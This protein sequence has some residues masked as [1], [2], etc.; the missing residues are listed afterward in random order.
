[1]RTIF[2]VGSRACLAC[3]C[4]LVAAGLASASTPFVIADFDGDGHVDRAD[5]NGGDQS[6]VRVWLSATGR[7]SVLR[8]ATPGLEMVARDLDGDRRAELMVSS[9]SNGLHIWKDRGERVQALHPKHA[10]TQGVP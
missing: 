3:L 6:A 10:H 5:L 2:A 4:V 8:S 7:T 9:T 1:M